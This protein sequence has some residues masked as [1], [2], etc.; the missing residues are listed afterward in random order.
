MNEGL[1]FGERLRRLTHQA[2]C[3]LQA[4]PHAAQVV[5]G[6]GVEWAA[7]QDV[8]ER[9]AAKGAPTKAARWIRHLI[10]EAGEAVEHLERE[11]SSEEVLVCA[12]T[13]RARWVELLRDRG[14]EVDEVEVPTGQ[15]FS[16]LRE[17]FYKGGRL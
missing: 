14:W 7:W 5:C 3:K 10:R 2:A 16:D 12:Q 4:A 1:T 6:S 17:W 13:V 15:E 9:C 11:G 8:R